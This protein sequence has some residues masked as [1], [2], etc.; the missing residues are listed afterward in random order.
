[1]IFYIKNRDSDHF[2]FSLNF[3]KSLGL[4]SVRSLASNNHKKLT[5]KLSKKLTFMHCNIIFLFI[6]IKIK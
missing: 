5:F 2:L 3:S 6:G 4:N 1:M